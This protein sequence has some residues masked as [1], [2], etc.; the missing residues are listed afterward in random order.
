[1]IIYEIKKNWHSCFCYNRPSHLKRVLIALEDCKIT[2]NINLIIDGP[3]NLGD[4]VNQKSMVLMANRFK[5]K[6]FKV[7]WRKKNF[8]L[9]KSIIEGINRFSKKYD[10]LII[11]EDDVV[12]YKSFFLFIQK[13]FLIIIKKETIS[14]RFADIKNKNFNSYKGNTLKTVLL[15][16]FTPWGL[17]DQSKEMGT[18]I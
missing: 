12:P 4:K 7:I 14:L 11:L 3:K 2:S 15:N 13:F 16:N 9:S 10:G 1:M 17:G 5:N 6:N 18:S 8:G